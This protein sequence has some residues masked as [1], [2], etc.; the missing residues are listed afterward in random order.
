MENTD[1]KEVRVLK[2]HLAL[3][4]KNV[5][6]SL[7]FYKKMLGIEPLKVRTGYA[8]F[9]VQNPPLNLTLNQVSFG[10]RGAL[11][12]L[13]LQVA[14]TEDVLEMRRKWAEA[15]LVTRDE[16][17]TNCCYAVQDKTWVHDPDGNAWEVFVVLKDNLAE[18]TACCATA[19]AEQSET[20]ARAE[21]AQAGD[22]ATSKA[23][24]SAST[25]ETCGCGSISAE[26]IVASSCCASSA[27]PVS[28][29]R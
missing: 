5:E 15:G 8:K 19:E 3:N 28:L 10:E 16:M 20:A 26:E 7:E 9:D 18:T 29:S 1:T 23:S 14:S 11:S 24:V 12:H 2:A 17:Q 4:V 6:R 21:P 22:C 27:T 25:G 13:G